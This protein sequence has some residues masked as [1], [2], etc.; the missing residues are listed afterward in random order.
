VFQVTSGSAYA[1]RGVVYLALRAPESALL[2]SEIAEA[3]EIPERYLAKIFQGLARHG[4]LRS[5]RGI[6][7]GF[8]LGRAASRITL[9]DIV[10]TCEGPVLVSKC[11]TKK[12]ECDKK[13]ICGMCVFWERLQKQVVTLLEKTT[14]QDIL[15]SL[16]KQ[17]E[18]A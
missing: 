3:H 4:V 2:V 7:G 6:G 17:R 16:A 13:D 10:K 11:L 9:M 1:I 15:D 18:A 12:G 14:I 5:T 8:S